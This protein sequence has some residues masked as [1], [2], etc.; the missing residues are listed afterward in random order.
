MAT[1]LVTTAKLEEILQE[2]LERSTWV[3]APTNPFV[4]S[5]REFGPAQLASGA[6]NAASTAGMA[7]A[8]VDPVVLGAAGPVAEKIGFLFWEAGKAMRSNDRTWGQRFS[9]GVKGL[10][11]N[12]LTDALY[13]DPAQIAM[14][15]ALLQQGHAPA[16]A[17]GLGF[18]AAIP[19]A[20]ALQAATGEVAH[21]GLKRLS[22]RT[23]FKWE[24][25]FESR[26]LVL[27]DQDASEAFKSVC[28]KFDLGNEKTGLY[29]DRYHKH[30]FPAFGNRLGLVRY[31]DVHGLTPEHKSYTDVELT[32][33]FLKRR[34]HERSEY[35]LFYVEK[36]KG[37]IHIGD[38]S[39]SSV[40][41]LNRP[42][43][44]EIDFVRTV[45]YDDEIRVAL[46]TIEV[47]DK[48]SFALLELK[49]RSESPEFFAAMTHLLRHSSLLTSTY[50]KVKL[51]ERIREKVNSSA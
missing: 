19:V 44:T 46:D 21:R 43:E 26:F 42:T 25:Y 10:G 40:Q 12:V 5:F 15:Y 48:H 29:H 18:L 17:G 22:Q 28:E 34:S 8:T 37:Y 4:K 2:D 31:R 32:Y 36:E 23:G 39:P 35:N 38:V 50:P 47:D 7:L 11:S 13:H 49:S 3:E 1:N 6:F 16:I 27:A 20:S 30:R 24:R 9:E 45:R 33:T 41:S 51:L 14:T